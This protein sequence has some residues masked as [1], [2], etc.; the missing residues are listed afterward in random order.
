[1]RDWDLL[2]SPLNSKEAI[3]KVVTGFHESRKGKVEHVSWES[4]LK[5]VSSCL[6]TENLRKRYL[7]LVQLGVKLHIEREDHHVIWVRNVDIM[8]KI[9]IRLAYHLK[10]AGL[11]DQEEDIFFLQ[12]PE[13]LTLCQNPKTALCDAT[14]LIPNRRAAFLIESKH[15]DRVKRDAVAECEEDYY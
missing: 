7:H 12:L 4:A 9:V 5:A 6:E 14:E 13:I 10:E 2:Y 8:R 11:L 1:M 3:E 15:F